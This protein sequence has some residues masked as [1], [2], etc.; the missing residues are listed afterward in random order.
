MKKNIFL[1]LIVLQPLLD[2][3]AFWTADT[4]GTL[5]GIIRLGILLVILI[6]LI[7]KQYKHKLFWI[8]GIICFVVFGG[9]IIN[10]YRCG[11][12][13]FIRDINYVVRVA[14]MP[15]MALFF[16]L[17]LDDE[18]ISKQIIKGL[19]INAVVVSLVV[20]VS[21][22]T[23]TFT[24]TYGEGLGI[25]G[26]V[27]I[28]NR[29]AHS[30][31]LST[32]CIFITYI[33]YKTKRSFLNLLLPFIV[34]VLL[35]TNGTRACYFTLTAVSI[36]FSIFLIIRS[37]IL[38][39][40]LFKNYIIFICSMT[41]VLGAS[42][43]LYPYSPRAAEE[44][45]KRSHFSTV[46]KEFVEKMNS[47]GY[48][49]YNMSLEKKMSDP[50]VH[51]ELRTYYNAFCWGGIPQIVQNFDLDTIIYKYGGIIESGTLGDTR[52]M[53]Q[54][55]AS[56]IMDTKDFSTHLFGFEIACLGDDMIVDMEN[57]W[58]AILYYYGYVGLFSYVL[59]ALYVFYRIIRK[60]FSDFK[61]SITDINFT[62]MFA[63]AILL[64]LAYFSGAVLRRPNVSFYYALII[65]MLYHETKYNSSSF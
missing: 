13:S 36:C 37:F 34:F 29:C 33:S 8:V 31:I 62:L 53:K 60:L 45:Y 25:S 14:F 56:L 11:Y 41:I 1:I 50:V 32:L 63:F 9:H 47:M 20:F 35:Y 4:R 48:D 30:D 24:F 7:I 22:I 40:K 39:Q 46:E 42:Y 10:S 52:L 21:Y 19:I 49:I 58:Y 59:L 57:D 17:E 51:E 5:A 3:L 23:N 26:W 64:G 16:C 54:K 12:L 15:V 27:T 18:I 38:K 2:I 6:Y 28:D 65:G 55:Y 61:T 44:E 43:F